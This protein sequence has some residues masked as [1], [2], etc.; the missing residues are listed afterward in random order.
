MLPCTMCCT[1]SLMFQVSLAAFFK[2]EFELAGMKWLEQ[3]VLKA[4]NA[5][6]VRSLEDAGGGKADEKAKCGR[7]A[8]MVQFH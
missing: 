6:T 2:I 3:S 7:F 1:W 4:R 5:R 8:S